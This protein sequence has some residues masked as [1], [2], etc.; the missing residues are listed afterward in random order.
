M[1]IKVIKSGEKDFEEA[2]AKMFEPK[3]LTKEEQLR[4]VFKKTLEDWGL[5]GSDIDNVAYL[6]LKEVKIRF[7]LK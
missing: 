1:E 6:L 4:L 5:C 3:V 7:N 2:K